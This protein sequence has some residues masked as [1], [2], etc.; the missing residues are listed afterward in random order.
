MAP[1][2]PASLLGKGRLLVLVWELEPQP[3]P[4]PGPEPEPEQ[5]GRAHC[6]EQPPCRVGLSKQCPAIW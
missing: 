1:H 2:A 6:P 4:G 5:D 3:E